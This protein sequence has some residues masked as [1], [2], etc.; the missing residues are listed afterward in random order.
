MYMLI[1]AQ[2]FETNDVVSYRIVKTLIIK[3]GINPNI[4]AEKMWVVHIFQQNICELDIVLTRTGNILTTNEL[5][6]LMMLWTTRPWDFIPS[7]WHK[8]LFLA[9]HMPWSTSWHIMAFKMNMHRPDCAHMQS[10]LVC[11]CWGFM[12]Q[13]TQWGHVERGQFT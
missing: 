1:W 6:K 8:G 9:L 10:G 11:L 7:I 12:A 5:I 13:S 3:Y 2:L 4:F